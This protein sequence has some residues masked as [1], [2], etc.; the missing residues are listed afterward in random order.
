MSITFKR[1]YRLVLA[2]V[3]VIVLLITLFPDTR[4]VAYTV[5]GSEAASE[6]VINY[7][8][9]V[10]LFDDT[11]VHEIVVLISAVGPVAF[12]IRCLVFALVR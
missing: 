9:D 2:L 11:V 5:A 12:G 10:D 1:H 8:N 6:T 3:L 4:I 7:D